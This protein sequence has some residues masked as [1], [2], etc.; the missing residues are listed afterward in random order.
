[1]QTMTLEEFQAALKAQG[2]PGVY[3]AMKCPMCQTVQSCADLIAAG[4]ARPLD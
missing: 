3:A 4:V 1:M 2:V